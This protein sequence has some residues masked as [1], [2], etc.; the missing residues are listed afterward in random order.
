[1]N[2]YCF[3]LCSI[4]WG[5]FN[6]HAAIHK[7]STEDSSNSFIQSYAEMVKQAQLS[8]VANTLTE[9]QIQQVLLPDTVKRIALAFP[10]NT[11]LELQSA[12]LLKQL[13]CIDN[14]AIV[15][16]TSLSSCIVLPPLTLLHSDISKEIT[17]PL[18]LLLRNN[19]IQGYNVKPNNV[20]AD[21]NTLLYGHSSLIHAKQ[22][23]A[24]LKIHNVNFTWQLLEKTSAFNIRDGWNDISDVEKSENIRYAQEYDLLLTFEDH[25]NKLKFMPLVSQYAKRNEQSSEQ[26]SEQDKQT[27]IID[28]W[29][30]PFYRSFIDEENYKQVTRINMISETHTAST[31]TLNDGKEEVLTQIKSLLDEHSTRFTI[32][33]EYIWVNPAFYRYLNGKYQ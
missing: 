13:G 23:V 30:Q 20:Q 17:S 19:V 6:S 32:S 3:I 26:S 27:L 7:T 10:K 1:M 31:L 21:D 9:T 18:N 33:T 14:S 25:Q 11:I 5:S 29:W 8:E 24:L 28:A 2:K 16:P 15:K 12:T 4:L 22:L